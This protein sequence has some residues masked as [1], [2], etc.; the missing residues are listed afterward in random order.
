MKKN[1]INLFTDIFEKEKESF[2]ARKYRWNWKSNRYMI[3]VS[4]LLIWSI[5]VILFDYHYI[6][7]EVTCSNAI[8]ITK[9]NTVIAKATLE[10]PVVGI[11]CPEPDD[12]GGC[13]GYAPIGGDFNAGEHE[14]DG[15]AEWK[16]CEC[17]NRELKIIYD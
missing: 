9:Q 2:P 5:S 1:D 7:V 3:M 13:G 11:E 4:I 10:N 16:K 14:V 12:D 17:S 6:C 8:G 15:E